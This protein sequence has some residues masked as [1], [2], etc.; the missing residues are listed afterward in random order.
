M[1]CVQQ[2]SAVMC[3]YK[4]LWNSNYPPPPPPFFFHGSRRG[5]K[6][7][8]NWQ[9]SQMTSILASEFVIHKIMIEEWCFCILLLLQ[10]PE[11][12]G[13]WRCYCMGVLKTTLASYCP[14]FALL[15]LHSKS[16]QVSTQASPLECFS[17]QRE[18]QKPQAGEK[19][20]N[21]NRLQAV[22]FALFSSVSILAMRW[23]YLYHHC[24]KKLTLSAESMLLSRVGYTWMT[25]KCHLITEYE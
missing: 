18:Y 5:K 25:G 14:A 20:D 15:S 19:E 6:N 22:V 21:H 16:T 13:T 11:H 3:F 4:F 12:R 7:S 8:K 1:A 2:S 9:R 10:R 23:E 24:L 17:T